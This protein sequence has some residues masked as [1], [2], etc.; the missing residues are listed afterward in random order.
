LDFFFFPR[1]FPSDVGQAAAM[2]RRAADFDFVRL[3]TGTTKFT[4]NKNVA[5]IEPTTSFLSDPIKKNE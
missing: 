4:A 3:Y 2:S 1:F 5:R